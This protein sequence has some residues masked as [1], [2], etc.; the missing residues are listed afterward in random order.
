V[1][2]VHVFGSL[3][4]ALVS[5]A[6][7]VAAFAFL[8]GLMLISLFFV[9]VELIFYHLILLAHVSVLVF[10]LDLIV[11]AGDALETSIHRV[12]FLIVGTSALDPAAA[13]V[14]VILV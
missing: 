6:E 7:H 12:L 11:A 14:T 1:V 8:V 3:G 2:F 10:L 5:N 13:T 9:R 4:F